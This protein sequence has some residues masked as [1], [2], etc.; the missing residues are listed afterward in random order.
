VLSIREIQQ[1]LSYTPPEQVDIVLEL[2]NLI[3]EVAPDATEVTRARTRSLS[4]YF[5][6]NHGGPVSA[7][8]CGISLKDDHV[9]LSFPHGAF[10]PDPQGLLTGKGKAMRH[11]TLR[12]YD[13]V[14]WDA[15]RELIR[16]HAAF[17]PRSYHFI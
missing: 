15:A 17:D 12:S 4:Y 16:E 7:G 14:P 1:F 5:S 10:I 2:R 13:T 9:Q 3:F 8:V 6:A 11:L